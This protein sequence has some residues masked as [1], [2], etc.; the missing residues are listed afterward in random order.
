MAHC[1]VWGQF[2]ILKSLLYAKEEG[3]VPV[4]RKGVSAD[5]ACFP[6]LFVSYSYRSKY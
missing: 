5:D 4:V 2:A 6:F 1:H 3:R